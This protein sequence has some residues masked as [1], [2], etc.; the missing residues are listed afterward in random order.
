MINAVPP[1]C[2]N[3][4]KTVSDLASASHFEFNHIRD[5][6]SAT[7]CGHQM[8]FTLILAGDDVMKR[9]QDLQIIL[10]DHDFPS[11]RYFVADCRVS[12]IISME[13]GQIAVRIETLLIES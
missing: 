1:C 7:F 4:A 6:H 3:L 10:P 2:W 5:W 12:S 13:D 8:E 9:A 11:G